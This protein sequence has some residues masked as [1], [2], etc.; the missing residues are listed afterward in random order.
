MGASRAGRARRWRRQR[1]V[2]PRRQGGAAEHGSQLVQ[3]HSV[4]CCTGPNLPLL[5]RCQAVASARGNNRVAA[6]AVCVVPALQP[7][8]CFTKAWEIAG[9]TSR[10]SRQTRQLVRHRRGPRGREARTTGAQFARG[11]AGGPIG[12]YRTPRRAATRHRQRRTPPEST[13]SARLSVVCVHALKSRRAPK[14]EAKPTR[15]G[16][17]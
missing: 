13:R 10:V 5:S 2:L 4:E 6:A 14:F 12:S 8:N 7:G 16:L 1:V 3:L 15:F 9:C 17:P 11:R